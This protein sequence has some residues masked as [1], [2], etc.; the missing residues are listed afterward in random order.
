MGENILDYLKPSKTLEKF[1][2]TY[3]GDFRVDMTDSGSIKISLGH[4][5]I[6]GYALEVANHYFSGNHV[7]MVAPNG[8]GP[9]PAFGVYRRGAQENDME[10]LLLIDPKVPQ[11]NYPLTRQI[12]GKTPHAF[13][14]STQEFELHPSV[15]IPYERVEMMARR[16]ACLR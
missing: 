10:H 16:I 8:H 13:R 1:G 14:V 3:E 5:V 7:E 11:E 6:V 4:L 12:P 9:N 2:T 15:E